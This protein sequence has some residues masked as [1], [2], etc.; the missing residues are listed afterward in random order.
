MTKPSQSTK[1]AKPAV[2]VNPEAAASLGVAVSLVGA[3]VLEMTGAAFTHAGR[4]VANKA[5]EVGRR[6]CRRL[7]GKN[8]P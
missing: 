8:C 3:H 7:G 2:R 5:V 4:A 1:P 6:D